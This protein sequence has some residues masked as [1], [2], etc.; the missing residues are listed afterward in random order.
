MEAFKYRHVASFEYFVVFRTIFLVKTN[1]ISLK[2]WLKILPGFVIQVVPAKGY[3]DQEN[4][5]SFNFPFSFVHQLCTM[6]IMDSISKSKGN[7]F[8]FQKLANFV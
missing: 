2:Y 5:C 1:N 3:K 8:G 6:V 4:I 7:F